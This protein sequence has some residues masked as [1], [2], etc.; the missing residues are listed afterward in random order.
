[1]AA[2]VGTQCHCV[3]DDELPGPGRPSRFQHQ[4]V[5]QIPLVRDRVIIGWPQE[6]VSGIIV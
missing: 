4:A 1:M 5:R 3:M 6:Q 2:F